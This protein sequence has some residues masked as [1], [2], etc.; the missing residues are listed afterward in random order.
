M[1]Y[2]L[3]AQKRFVYISLMTCIEK[4]LDKIFRFVNSVVGTLVALE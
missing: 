1:I 3:D 2:A 4:V